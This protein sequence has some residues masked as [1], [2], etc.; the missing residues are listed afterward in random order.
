[1]RAPVNR[2]L[3]CPTQNDFFEMYQGDVQWS[4]NG[5]TISGFG[6]VHGMQTFNLLGG[7]VE[8]DMDTSHAQPGVNSDFYTT[9][10]SKSRFPLYCD[11][12]GVHD[13]PR[14]MELDIVETNGN[15][16]SRTTWHLWPN[17][18]GGCDESGCWGEQWTVSGRRHYKASFA[19]DGFM[20]VTID[21]VPVNVRNP[22]VPSQ[23]TVQAVKRNT[24]R[25]GLQLHMTAWKS[26][27]PLEDICPPYGNISKSVFSVHN[28]RVYGSVVQGPQATVCGN[29]TITTSVTNTTSKNN[30]IRRKKKPRFQQGKNKT[31]K[32]AKDYENDFDVL[33]SVFL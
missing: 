3:Y 4:D 31:L 7:Y 30:R 9:S 15:C 33:K 12:R 29:S 16:V 2:Q 24:Q 20:T 17:F 32:N 21:G 19:N 25:L 13:S 18:D 22:M 11:I 27:E 8:Y 1:M 28:L 23:T 10:P 26:W 6:G 5:V 14:C